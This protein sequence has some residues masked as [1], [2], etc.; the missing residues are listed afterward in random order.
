[1]TFPTIHVTGTFAPDPGFWELFKALAEL[2]Q[3]AADEDGGMHTAG[4]EM[5]V[6]YE[7]GQFTVDDLMMEA[8]A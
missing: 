4:V 5:L 3:S 6:G 2:M 7:D 8:R 1:M